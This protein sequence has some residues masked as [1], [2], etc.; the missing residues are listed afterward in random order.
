M[1]MKR[2]LPCRRELLRDPSAAPERASASAFSLPPIHSLSSFR[3]KPALSL[4]LAFNYPI[5]QWLNLLRIISLSLSTFPDSPSPYR[6]PCSDNPPISLT[7]AS[8]RHDTTH[9][10]VLISLSLACLLGCLIAIDCAADS[11]LPARPNSP[12]QS[13]ALSFPSHLST[14]TSQASDFTV[15]RAKRRTRWQARFWLNRRTRALEHWHIPRH[16]GI[17]PGPLACTTTE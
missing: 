10:I 15:K 11:S 14:S 12:L 2:A 13:L 3:I 16:A 4:S 6:A 17:K 5:I 9:L 8:D 1:M 7:F